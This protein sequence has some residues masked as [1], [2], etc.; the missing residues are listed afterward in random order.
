[1]N[2]LFSNYKIRVARLEDLAMLAD[3][4]CAAAKL[5]C[6]TPY[7]FLADDQPLPLDFVTQ[8]FAA[9]RVWVAVDDR[10]QPVGYAITQEV[11][12]NAYLRQIDVHPAHG[13]RGIGRKLVD[14]VC[15]WAKHERYQRIFLSTFT[16]V[17]WNAPFYTKIGFQILAKDVLTSGFQQ[18]RHR[19]AE[20]GLPIEQRVIMYRDLGW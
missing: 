18:I 8:Q 9:D 3:I 14:S 5:F 19:E 10:D 12:G 7:A 6:N 17:E 13:R 20:A 2:D 16:D 11:D 1:M 4:E 15:V